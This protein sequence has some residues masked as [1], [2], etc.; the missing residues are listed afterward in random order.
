MAV[1]KVLAPRENNNR[2]RVEKGP[3]AAVMGNTKGAHPKLPS[4]SLCPC[5]LP[6]A[7]EHRGLR[8]VRV[9][10]AARVA[11]PPTPPPLPQ[12]RTLPKPCRVV[13]TAVVIRRVVGAVV[14][15]VAGRGDAEVDVEEVATPVATG[16]GLVQTQGKEM[17]LLPPLQPPRPRGRNLIARCRCPSRGQMTPERETAVGARESGEMRWCPWHPRQGVVEA[18]VVVRLVGEVVV[19]AVEVAVDEAGKAGNRTHLP[20]PLPYPLR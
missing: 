4:P 20:R 7:R 19:V 1:A 10:K 17:V 12:P 13:P 3:A 5:R 16:L 9:A 18:G 8:R 14:V 6:R 11:A 15:E 2:R